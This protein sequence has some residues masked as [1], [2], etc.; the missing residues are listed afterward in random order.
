MIDLKKYLNTIHDLGRRKSS[1]DLEFILGLSDIERQLGKT[2][3][4]N[5]KGHG[6]IY[7][8]TS[9]GQTMGFSPANT[10]CCED[11]SNLPMVL[12][13]SSAMKDLLLTHSPPAQIEPATT[14][15]SDSPKHSTMWRFVVDPELL[16]SMPHQT[17]CCCTC[18]CMIFR[19]HTFNKIPQGVGFRMRWFKIFFHPRNVRLRE[20]FIGKQAWQPRRLGRQKSRF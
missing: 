10:L 12:S 13:R 4:C 17:S 6:N 19:V 2:L 20:D 11:L 16:S 9:K 14:I 18:L 7:D 15:G 1:S 5:D 3:I 8:S